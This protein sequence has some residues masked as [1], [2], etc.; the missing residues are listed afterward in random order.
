[1][2]SSDLVLRGVGKRRHS[3]AMESFSDPRR[4]I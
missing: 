1:V 2:V 3:D 4:C